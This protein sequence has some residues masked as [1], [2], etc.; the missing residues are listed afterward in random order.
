MRTVK[1]PICGKTELVDDGDVCEV[2]GWFHDVVQEANPDEENCENEMSLNQYKAAYE[3]GWRPDWLASD[4]QDAPNTT[5]EEA[6][7]DSATTQ[8]KPQEAA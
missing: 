3:S 8:G 6:G 7:S 2:C 1:C 4:D 5:E